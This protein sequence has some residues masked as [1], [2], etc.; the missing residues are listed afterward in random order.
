MLSEQEITQELRKAVQ[1]FDYM[2]YADQQA[3]IKTRQKEVQAREPVASTEVIYHAPGVNDTLP[4]LPP[5]DMVEAELRIALKNAISD[6][7]QADV[8]YRHAASL[9]V[10][11]T[12][13]VTES[14]VALAT[15]DSLPAELAEFEV[16]Q[17][18]DGS[19]LELPYHLAQATKDQQVAMDKLQRAIAAKK[20]LVAEQDKIAAAELKCKRLVMY[21]IN[22]VCV[23]IARQMTAELLSLEAKAHEL[24][25]CV[26]ALQLPGGNNMP[27]DVVNPIYAPKGDI[28]VSEPAKDKWIALQLAL[29]SDADATLG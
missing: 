4:R 11:A 25:S 3:L 17:L 19:E 24:R 20:Q 2:S 5:A 14:E 7:T 8:A 10:K 16:S 28:R 13:R 27:A 29:R 23:S 15:Y 1:S 22:A 26:C 12:A 9:V 6:A 21:F 18:K